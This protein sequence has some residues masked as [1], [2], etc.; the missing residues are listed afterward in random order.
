LR[1]KTNASENKK[2]EESISQFTLEISRIFVR[3][4]T[5]RG[6]EPLLS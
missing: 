5:G 3:A 2:K 1:K 6:L 4:L